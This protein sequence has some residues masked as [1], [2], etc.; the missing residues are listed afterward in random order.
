M[1]ETFLPPHFMFVVQC[2]HPCF[3]LLSTCC[4]LGV[5]VVVCSHNIKMKKDTQEDFVL[6]KKSSSK[7]SI[8]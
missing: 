7:C 1:K 5:V 4:E 8:M 3:A 6:K 2:C